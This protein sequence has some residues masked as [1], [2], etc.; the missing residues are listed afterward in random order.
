[1]IVLQVY[2]TRLFVTLGVFS[3][4]ITLT[5]FVRGDDGE[6]GEI[7]KSGRVLVG[8]VLVAVNGSAV[9][10]HATPSEVARI[11]TRMPRPLTVTFKRAS[12]DMLE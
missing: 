11:V 3:G 5:S 12:W 2:N 4:R 1:M 9:G 10:A 6:C 7:E 8:D